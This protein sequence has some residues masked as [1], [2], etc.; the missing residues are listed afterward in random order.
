ML[1]YEQESDCDMWIVPIYLL[2]HFLSSLLGE[3]SMARSLVLEQPSEWPP[4][5]SVLSSHI[6]VYS[7]LITTFEVVKCGSGC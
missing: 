6:A 5:L 2:M 7:R 1:E 3:S 4:E